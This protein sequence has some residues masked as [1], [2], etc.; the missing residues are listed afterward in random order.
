[1]NDIQSAETIKIKNPSSSSNESEFTGLVHFK[2]KAVKY[3]SKL[4]ESDIDSN[5]ID[6][7]HYLASECSEVD[8]LV[9]ELY[10]EL[11][12]HELVKNSS[13][14]KAVLKVIIINLY[15]SCISDP[16]LCIRYSRDEN[17]H[18]LKNRY[19]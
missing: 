11:M 4:D 15:S 1:M 17:F 3:L 10:L 14:T 6:L 2:S 5:L 16:E 13:K 18:S 9:H 7:L 8:A 19:V 12:G